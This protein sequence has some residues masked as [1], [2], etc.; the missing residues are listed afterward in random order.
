MEAGLLLGRDADPLLADDSGLEPTKFGAGRR[1]KPVQDT[2]WWRILHA[3]GFA[4]G[5]LTF[6][7]GT[8][9]YFAPPSDAIEILAAA[10]YII[11]SLGFLT[12]D[13]ME[14]YTPD[15]KVLPLRYNIAMSATGSFF[16]VLG[17]IGYLPSILAQTE[18]LGVW[19]FI[20]GSFLIGCSQAW[21]V[22]RLSQGKDGR[23]SLRTILGSSDIFTAA[24]VEAG[25][26]MGAWL[27]FAGTAFQDANGAFDSVLWMWLAGSV[28]FTSGAAFLAY[29]H[30]VM[31]IS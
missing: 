11:G 9:L 10:L 3:I 30:F 31:G 24:G 13:V 27:F 21:K 12:V 6:I 5:G 4:T 8:A 23:Y 22:T 16:Y 26:G 14:F 29:R 15:Y 17:S 19:G 2:T 20:V 1:K 18:A 7:V 28:A 25:A